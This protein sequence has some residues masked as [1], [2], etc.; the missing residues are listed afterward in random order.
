[1]QLL[2][3]VALVAMAATGAWANPATAACDGY[4]IVVLGGQSNAVGR[5]LTGAWS[6]T[7][8]QI[9][10]KPR[11]FETV[12]GY[13]SAGDPAWIYLTPQTFQITQASE[14]LMNDSNIHDVAGRIGFAYSFALLLA[15]QE[16]DAKRCV[17]I[18][19]AAR[20][21]TSI[22]AWNLVD[23]QYAGD[24][25]FFYLDM[26]SR[27]KLALAALPNPRVV[28]FLWLQGEADALT[29]ASI[30]T[31]TP[32]RLATLMPNA[33]TYLS[34]LQIVMAQ[35]RT[36]LGCVPAML[37][38]LAPSFI[39]D[40]DTNA[41]IEANA[42]AVKG[43]IEAAMQTVANNDSCKKMAVISSTGLLTNA[44][45]VVTT[46]FQDFTHFSATSQIALSNRF[47]KEYKVLAGKK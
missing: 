6:L 29:I 13:D 22:L 28:A 46:G 45:Q 36:D 15:S 20:S 10:A 33:A 34:Q 14:P 31:P 42:E 2:L 40:F 4:D 11:V 23:R 5:G 35:M 27:T 12:R 16:S 7:A 43:Q 37:G 19:P 38:N 3:R 18:V 9:A 30:D 32:D 17:L 24:L 39:S 47:Y 41:A 21:G 26:I 1:M 25:A 44:Q 8:A